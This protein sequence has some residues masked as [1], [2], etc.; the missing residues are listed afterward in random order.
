MQDAAK[1]TVGKPKTGG[2]I[3]CAP[4]GTVL[5]NSATTA[6]DEAFNCLGYIS[7]DGLTNANS[8]ETDQI[9]AWGGDVV[10]NYQ[11]AKPDTFSFALLEAL[12]VAVLKAVYGDENVSGTLDTG[13]TLTANSREQQPRAWVF[14]M[15]LV[16]GALKRVVIP[17]AAITETEDITYKDDEAVGYGIT[18]SA[19]PDEAGNTHY[20]YI[21]KKAGAE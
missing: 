17:S 14:D 11:T 20:E 1:V 13:I 6:L 8:P 9:K 18:L 4:L 21:Q 7:E 3:F 15:I 12:N 16:G 19:V 2:A 10:Y 5:P